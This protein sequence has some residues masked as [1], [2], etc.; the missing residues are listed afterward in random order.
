MSVQMIELQEVQMFEISDDAL[1]MSCELLK[2]PT[3]PVVCNYY[4]P[5]Q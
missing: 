1:E 3:D 4:C 5:I 2:G